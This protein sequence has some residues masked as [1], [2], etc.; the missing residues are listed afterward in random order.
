M[1][2]LAP[3]ERENLE[4]TL[5]QAFPSEAELARAVQ[6]AL[7][8]NLAAIAGNGPLEDVVF[9]LINWAESHNK[10]AD[11][12]SGA[13]KVNSDNVA[14][15]ELNAAL[16]TLTGDGMRRLSASEAKLRKKYLEELQKDIQDRLKE[17][18]HNARFIDIGVTEDLYATHLPWRYRA[19]DTPEEFANFRDAFEHSKRR[20]LLLGAPGAGK[21]T[22][23]LHIARLLVQEALENLQAPV[24]LLLNLTQFSTKP[25]QTAQRWIPRRAKEEASET[26]ATPDVEHWLARMMTE[27]YPFIDRKL[28]NRWVKEERVAALLDG[29]DEVAAEQRTELVEIINRSYLDRYPFVTVVICSR[30]I[31]YHVLRAQSRT[32]REEEEAGLHLEAVTLQPL[33][34]QQIADYLEKAQATALGEALLYDNA[35]QELARIPLTLSMMT[36]AY[37]GLAPTEM[38][39]GQSLTERRRHLFN[40]YVDRMMQRQARRDAGIPFDLD[41]RKD[42]PTKYSRPQL[43]RAL[44]W[45]AVRMSERAQTMVPLNR[46]HTFLKQKSIVKDNNST[47]QLV[48]LTD[49]LVVCLF[50]FIAGLP[51]V[52]FAL[53]QLSLLLL[54]S[55]LTGF[56]YWLG[57]NAFDDSRETATEEQGRHHWLHSYSLP[58]LALLGFAVIAV[59]TVGSILIALQVVLPGHLPGLALGVMITVLIVGTIFVSEEFEKIRQ[60]NVYLLITLTSMLVPPTL[61]FFTG[62]MSNLWT[63]TATFMGIFQVFYFLIAHGWDHTWRRIEWRTVAAIFGLGGG[64]LFAQWLGI[65]LV[66]AL[67]W[68]EAVVIT[69]AALLIAA[70]ANAQS[71]L[72][73][74]AIV[75]LMASPLGT[76]AV[77]ILWAAIGL[78][79]LL[80]LISM[81]KRFEEFKEAVTLY[82]GKLDTR[83]GA[84][85][86]HYLFTLLIRLLLTMQRIFPFNSKALF[87]YSSEIYLLKSAGNEQEFLH[88]LLRDYFATHELIPSLSTDNPEK[89]IQ[90]IRQLSL[91]GE[92]AVEILRDL[93]ENSGDFQIR[94]SAVR[95]ASYVA[96][97]AAT[98]ILERCLHDPV[99]AVRWE[100]VRSASRL[101][102]EDKKS[103]LAKAADDRDLSV[104]L[105]TLKESKSFYNVFTDGIVDPVVKTRKA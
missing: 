59:V 104:R 81:E 48:W 76:L 69:N 50:L 10:L 66:G 78:L 82:Y 20:L 30:V 54:L 27:K 12:I 88:R 74:V 72:V 37:A 94:Q 42:K 9:R 2:R 45:L 96:T 43:D 93:A 58:A 60:R 99:T 35:L 86:E 13:H 56:L 25:A 32:Q 17:S 57:R 67:D 41:P 103:I 98:L 19:P 6:F 63:I 22:V 87:A 8:E 85:L 79:A 77:V 15:R 91:Q 28:A 5:L 90:L 55:I 68:Y 11:L 61:V 92:A 75:T 40:L 21:S 64:L 97:P 70:F 24:P 39:L 102:D 52:P 3:N 7:N 31:E 80:L 36:L 84:L 34:P 18:I 65:W 26:N 51:L 44:G 49:A 89:I 23:L 38:G 101:T 33:S 14:L 46:L 71:I 100:V 83:I 73:G 47:S 1:H 16:G 62:A 53:S 105:L 29:L 95:G 4:S